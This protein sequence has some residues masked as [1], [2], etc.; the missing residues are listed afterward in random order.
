LNVIISYFKN[1]DGRKY[2]LAVNRSVVDSA[3]FTFTVNPA[4]STVKEISKS[5]GA[6]VNTNYSSGQLSGS[7]LPGEEGSYTHCLPDID[8]R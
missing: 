1:Y 8:L 7:F 5:T 3:T 6:E 2:I 4:P